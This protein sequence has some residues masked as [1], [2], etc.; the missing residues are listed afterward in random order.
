MATTHIISI[1]VGKGKT[2]HQSLKERLDY[3]INPEKTDGGILI[4]SHACSPETAA[5]EFMLYRQEYLNTTGRKRKDE[6]LAYHVRQAFK[7]GEITA[8]KANEIGK[9]M[10]ERLTDKQ[11]AFVVATHIDKQHIHNHIIL[12]ATNLDGQQKYRDVKRSAKDLM[13]IS[14]TLCE[15]NGLSVIRNPQDK[16]VPYD[17]WEGNLKKSSHRDDLRIMIDAALRHR[18][19]GFDALMQMLEDAGCCIKRGAHISLKLPNGQR[20]I[21]LKSLGPEY[22]ENTLRQTLAG[23]HVHIPKTPRADYSKNQIKRLVDIEDKL[24]NG[25]GKGYQ[26]WAERNNIDAISQTVIFLKEHHIGSL[27]ELEKQIDDLQSACEEK[28]ASIRQA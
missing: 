3:I 12:C 20:Y 27:E 25:K 8:E 28:K 14:D 24:R 5:D 22:D 23:D 11:Y 7:P 26:V 19:V 10:A 13:Q 21:R 9:E 4:S 18:P 6:V 17:K 16:A 1:H 2:A 15:E